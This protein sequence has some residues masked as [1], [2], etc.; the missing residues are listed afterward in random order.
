ML[1]AAPAQAFASESY[2]AW[3]G[4]SLA[5]LRGASE[6]IRCQACDGYAADTDG[7]G[8]VDR[9][10][11]TIQT[12]SNDLRQFTFASTR[13]GRPL[14]PGIYRGATRDDV[15]GRPQML[16]G[17]VDIC[18]INSTAGAFEILH[19]E[20]DT[21]GAVPRVVSFWARFEL[22]CNGEFYPFKGEVAFNVPDLPRVAHV[23]PS[24]NAKSLNIYGERI[25]SAT[26]LV[27]DGLPATFKIDAD[28]GIKARVSRLSTGRHDVRVGGPNGYLSPPFAF[29]VGDDPPFAKGSF[30]LDSDPGDLIGN[31]GTYRFKNKPMVV[32]T[33]LDLDGRPHEISI[34]V[35]TDEKSFSVSVTSEKMGA[36]LAIGS[37]RD[38]ERHPFEDI[39]KPGMGISASD[40]PSC[41]EILGNFAITSYGLDDRLLA[42]VRWISLDFDLHCDG[43]AAGLRGSTRMVGPEPVV[44]L[45][46][47]YSSAAR[48]LQVRATGLTRDVELWVDG[49]RLGPTTI[50][51]DVLE[52]SNVTLGAG[53][54]LISVFR[55]DVL[56]YDFSQPWLV[57]L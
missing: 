53:Q 54:H 21:T 37:Y 25:E 45:A 9:V 22:R 41:N 27:V 15:E 14:E 43:N 26:S 44:I 11:I 35:I 17:P 39:G 29:Y 42:R 18:Y 28:G 30:K 31:G 36:P 13:T 24:A 20:Y 1:A 2:A 8:A 7:D 51:G 52:L 23:Q 55:N 49:Q 48:T 47:S 10:T 3:S 12:P 6:L 40:R 57:T 33:Q 34:G 5:T 38:A 46:A 19:A 50:E 56:R 32:S 16:L 4:Y